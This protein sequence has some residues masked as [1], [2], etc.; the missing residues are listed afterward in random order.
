[1][2]ASQDKN[3]KTAFVYSNLYQLY[4][5]GKEAAQSAPV[6]TIQTSVAEEARKSYFQLPSTLPSEKNVLK[7]GDLKSEMAPKVNA[8]HP[9]SLLAKRLVDKPQALN[10]VNPTQSA[11]IESLKSNLKSLNDLHSRLRFMLEELED[12]V[13]D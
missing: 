7:S 10:Q 2:S 3:Q 11:A 5:K 4:R 6:N 13:K 9:P 12:L 8:Y 1:M